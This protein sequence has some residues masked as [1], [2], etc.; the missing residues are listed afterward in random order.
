MTMR[1][2][3]ELDQDL[4]ALVAKTREIPSLPA[5]A[6]QRLSR[7]LDLTLSGVVSATPLADPSA[8]RH[9]PTLRTA[10][11][12]GVSL[13]VGIALGLVSANL[14]TDSDQHLPS[15]A[16]QHADAS[17]AY[18]DASAKRDTVPTRDAA[19]GPRDSQAAARPL[20]KATRRASVATRTARDQ[21]LAH[22]RSLIEM[23]RSALAR[24]DAPAALEA[25]RL[26]RQAFGRTGQLGE[27]REALA[28]QA[29][30]NTKRFAEARRRAKA[31]LRKYPRTLLRPL[32]EK[33]AAAV[34]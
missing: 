16:S 12:S 8:A 30:I 18:A 25:T 9:L 26:H 20:R 33:A 24:G 6:K 10:L 23:A 17:V 14:W 21:R 28:I 3:D 32:I 34:R 22:E 11:L 13:V 31:F 7:R 1:N 27:E 19:V 29:L 5:S 4:R 15:T 2:I